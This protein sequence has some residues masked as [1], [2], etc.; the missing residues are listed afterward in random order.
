[1]QRLFFSAIT[2][3]LVLVLSAQAATVWQLGLDDNAWPVDG[4]GGGPAADF[5][6]ESTSSNPLPGDPLSPSIN[7]QADDDYY[8]AGL[9]SKV[10]DGSGYTPVG[11]VASDEIAAERAFSGVDNSLRYHFNLPSVFD[12]ANLL[13]VTFDA[14]NLHDYGGFDLRYG[15]EIW[16][17]GI[18]VMNEVI[19][20]RAEIR[21]G[22]R[23][24]W[25]GVREYLLCL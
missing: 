5:V 25:S 21:T 23:E 1:M 13:S 20:R 18:Q 3:P 8:F 17:N 22:V 12:P 2:S 16:F 11:V 6:V 19:I 4:V 14:Y 7:Y 10:L 15:V 9:Y 24:G